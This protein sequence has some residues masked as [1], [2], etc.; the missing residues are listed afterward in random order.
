MLDLILAVR[1]FGKNLAFSLVATITLALGVGANT[2]IFS[3][4]KAVLLNQLPYRDPDRLVTIAEAEP[5][6]VRP[7]TVDFT[8]TYD[9]RAR[10]RSFE[11]MSL[12][13]GWRSA[14]IG[15][16]DPELMNGLRVNY[17]YFDTLGVKMRLGR[18]FAAEDD[19][20]DR[21]NHVL[22]ISD[23][24][25]TRNFGRDPNI[26]GRTV[27][28]NESTFTIV[29]V[30]PANFRPVPLGQSDEARD[31]FAPLGYELNQAFACRG[32][33]HLRLIA[34]L[35]SSVGTREA[36]AEL[37]AVLAGIVREHADAYN[38]N[39][40]M[41]IT[42]LLE[43]VFGQVRTA[44]WVLL[45]AVSFVLLIA[46][47]N[48]AN[49]LLARATGRAKEI[50][51]RTALGAGRGRLIRQMLTESLALALA[52]GV[53]G[54]LLAVGG[55]S[56]LASA[57]PREIPRIVEVRID[58]MVLLF[59]VGASL[60]AGVLF[61]LAPALRASR[62]DLTDGLKG[63]STGGRGTVN[64]RDALVTVEFALAF[65]LV[66][67]AGLLGK[68]FVHLMNVDPGFDARNLLT[69]N[70]YVYAKRYA[71]PRVELN[72]YSQVFD[73]LR[74]N[75]EFESMAM[76]STLPFTNFDRALIHIQ[77][78]PLA[79]PNEAPNVDRYSVS[80]DYFHV[81]RIPLK[82]G[83]W[84]TEQDRRGSPAVAIVS[85]SCARTLFPKEDAIGKHIQLGGR[86]D[87]KPW[88]TIVG[89]AGDVRQYG[90][91]RAPNM[92]AYIPQAQDLSFTYT[93]V[94]RTTRDPRRMEGAVRAAFLAVDKTQPLFDVVPMETYL[95]AS[96]AERTF[97]LAL[98]GLFGVLALA[99]AAIGIYGVISY[100]VSLRTR[101]IGIRM[102]L[103]AKRSDVSGM[104]LRQ[105][106]A[107]TAAGLAAGFV[108]S[109]GLTRL[110]ASLLY[111]VH[112][113]DIATILGVAVLLTGVALTGSYVPARRAS[114][115]DP[116]I[117]LRSE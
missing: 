70:T 21:W 61:G 71:D 107:L 23:G 12:Y 26:V 29:G 11:S 18:T 111:E 42:L 78:R 64:L 57:A 72:Y 108:A 110:L 43:E 15:Q 48:V 31:I 103:G 97:T 51:L 102:A 34:R 4:V 76:V 87:N 105:G 40:R 2:A 38:S 32:C 7:L 109:L 114:K 33:Q 73:R 62:A 14:L 30:L 36:S 96:L 5:G 6:T 9:L 93:F 115:V 47:A 52:G 25:W 88:M 54:I 53:G 20:A 92:E 37:N 28:L 24:L 117:A 94:A 106:L 91:D 98:L 59:A 90:L 67:G 116:A 35:K 85:E 68:S 16:G 49:L 63:R 74:A 19:R 112:P 82:R 41:N 65:V 104:V 55:T 17:D 75:G 58:V 46:C 81:M 10:S 66:V 89:V 113:T 79:N 1:M 86:D 60:L 95:A 99:L 3:V 44:L 45:G 100:A 13:R 69:A 27:R 80:P 50:A 8:T 83:R 77:D 56:V 39:D 84:F 22:I 101:E